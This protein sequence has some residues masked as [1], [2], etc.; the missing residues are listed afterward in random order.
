MYEESGCHI[1]VMFD[2]GEKILPF[3]VFGADVRQR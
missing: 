3:Q 1:G 2:P